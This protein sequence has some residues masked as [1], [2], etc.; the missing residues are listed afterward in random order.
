MKVQD[1]LIEGEGVVKKVE[2]SIIP[3]VYILT[4]DCE[5]AVLKLDLVKDLL[6]FD[7]GDRVN[8]VISR[9]KPQFS[10][11]KDLVIWGYV[12]SKKKT[13]SGEK[14]NKLLIS[15]WGYL[16]IIETKRDDIID[17]FDYLDKVYFKMS[18]QA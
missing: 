10:E 15:L 5:E 18:K 14:P 1:G 16:L 3:K 13:L 4:V 8:I 12:L 7:E 17:S 11:G 2:K 9:E 6:I